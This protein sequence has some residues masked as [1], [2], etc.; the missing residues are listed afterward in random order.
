VT[1]GGGL[2]PAL[3]QGYDGRRSPSGMML[4]VQRIENGD[5]RRAAED[6]T[7]ATMVHIQGLQCCQFC[8]EEWRDRRR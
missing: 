4:G 7:A 1:W 8:K 2:R 6:V 5:G 3:R